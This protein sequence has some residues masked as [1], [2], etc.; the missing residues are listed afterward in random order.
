MR[1]PLSL[2]V[3]AFVVWC[4]A[5]TSAVA[6]GFAPVATLAAQDQQRI[7]E[8]LEFEQ[9]NQPV[10]LPG[11]R[12]QFTIVRTETRPRICRYFSLALPGRSVAQGVGCRISSR[13]WELSSVSVDVVPEPTSPILASP[14]PERGE[15]NGPPASGGVVAPGPSQVVAMPA[16]GTV[17]V[18]P[19][20]AAAPVASAPPRDQAPDAPVPGRHPD[21]AVPLAAAPP[22]IRTVPLPIRPAGRSDLLV[23][24]AVDADSVVTTT[25]SANT[26]DGSARVS[27]I[28]EPLPFEPMPTPSRP[29]ARADLQPPPVVV[30]SVDAD[31]VQ[32]AAPEPLEMLA[33]PPEMPVP[34]A[35]PTR[36][37][38]LADAT[39]GSEEVGGAPPVV[40]AVGA[41]EGE[42]TAETDDGGALE[43]V[44]AGFREDQ[45]LAPVDAENGSVGA[46]E[47]TVAETVEIA[48]S[49]VAVPYPLR[50]PRGPAFVTLPVA[51]GGDI[52]PTPRHKPLPPA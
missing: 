45:G 17:I 9:T 21:R 2:W 24:A 32:D 11:S 27:P 23:V 33:T 37:V 51:A 7:Q 1:R 14:R 13:Q 25:E 28:D 46:P 22:A 30:A 6:Q 42:A 16:P 12:G 3:V 52:I 49:P 34:V 4:A 44:L 38:E 50:P 18:A 20:T 40:E 8:I 36:V 43:E 15:S 26:G 19:P 39:A 10:V 29:D 47:V 41:A 48:E 35:H 5:S 31:D